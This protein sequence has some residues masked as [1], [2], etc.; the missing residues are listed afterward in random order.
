M[1][2]EMCIRDRFGNITLADGSATYRDVQGT[3]MSEEKTFP[4]LSKVSGN[5][6]ILYEDE[7]WG[8]R[9]STAFRGRYIFNVEAGLTD[10]DER[11]FHSTKY[12]DASIYYDINP[13]LKLTLEAS[14]LNN[15][16]EVQYSDSNN[17]A[18][19]TTS[20]GRSMYF[21]VNFKY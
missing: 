10:E 2:S 17:R 19:N 11:G 14:N 9:L 13:K 4:G 5:L 21:G 1:G 16:R 7:G 6:T 12:I 18:Y 3:G 15:Q 20:H 8:A